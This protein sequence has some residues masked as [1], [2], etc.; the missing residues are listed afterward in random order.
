MTLLNEFHYTLS[1]VGHFMPLSYFNC[2]VHSDLKDYMVGI[3]K[4]KLSDYYCCLMCKYPIIHFTYKN[5]IYWGYIQ[6]CKD[7]SVLH[8]VC[9]FV[10][11][12]LSVIFYRL[13]F[14]WSG[15]QLSKIVYELF[16]SF[17]TVFLSY[18]LIN[19]CHCLQ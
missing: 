9:F 10:G 17:L 8:C 16:N 3:S 13:D 2:Q 1:D 7:K 11:L 4:Q 6:C 15:L 14:F 18:D 5:G 19:K 12:F